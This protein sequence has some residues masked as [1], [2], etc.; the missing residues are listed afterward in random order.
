VVYT[1]TGST[2]ISTPPTLLMGC[3]MVLLS[4]T[5]VAD[6]W[7]RCSV[8]SVTVCLCVCVCPRSN[9]RTTRAINSKLGAHIDRGTISQA[10]TLRSKGQR[11]RSH[12]Y[13]MR[14]LCGYAD[15]DDCLGFYSFSRVFVHTPGVVEEWLE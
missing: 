7:V 11:S 2:E 12:S 13:Q 8:T 1:P 10:A 6:A 3:G 14:C 15:R 5:P 9:R 4:F